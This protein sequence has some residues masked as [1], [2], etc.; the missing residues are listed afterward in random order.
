MRNKASAVKNDNAQR[1]IGGITIRPQD[2]AIVRGVLRL[3]LPAGAK[4]CVFGSRARGTTKRAADLDLAIDAGRKLTQQEEM[5]LS[6]LFED[7]DLPYKVD[8]VDMCAVSD[9]F[10]E[11]ILSNNIPL[12]L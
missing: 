4:V 3:Y 6:T 8:I 9:A 10:K 7:S 2:L 5:A 12:I 1:I 11:I